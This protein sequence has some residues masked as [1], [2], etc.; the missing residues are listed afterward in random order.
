MWKVKYGY[1]IRHNSSKKLKIKC[2]RQKDKIK[3]LSKIDYAVS[4]YK[5]LCKNSGACSITGLR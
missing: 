2:T 1:M 5:T 4:P 3:L